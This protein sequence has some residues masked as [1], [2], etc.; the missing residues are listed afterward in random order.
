MRESSC[1][2]QAGRS[3]KLL[4][5]SL[6]PTIDNEAETRIRSSE[7]ARWCSAEDRK[8]TYH[9]NP[10]LRELEQLH[11]TK[12]SLPTSPCMYIHVVRT[13][14]YVRTLKTSQA[15]AVLTS[16]CCG[17]CCFFALRRD[18]HKSSA[19]VYPP[20][21]PNTYYQ[22]IIAHF[23]YWHILFPRKKKNA[24]ATETVLFLAWHEDDGEFNWPPRPP[25]IRGP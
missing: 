17:S 23:I 10:C 18:L 16:G 12:R 9:Q 19:T 2:E 24:D 6:P 15:T 20:D 5:R 1:W 14:T 7:S 4:L 13:W 3:R 8:S 21:P 11:Q 25:Q 22:Y